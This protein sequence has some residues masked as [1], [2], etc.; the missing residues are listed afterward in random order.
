MGMSLPL[1]GVI[2]A[3]AHSLDPIDG[4]TPD[5]LVIISRHGVRRQFPSSAFDFDKFAPGKHFAASDEEWGA[6]REGFG[7]LTDH[8]FEAVR[9]MGEA[10][11][12]R[13]AMVGTGEPKEWGPGVPL[14]NDI[15]GD[16]AVIYA[17]EGV[18]RD[19]KTAEAFFLGAGCHGRMPPM[20]H[21]G[22]EY[23]IDQGSTP[24]GGEG[25]CSLLDGAATAGRVGGGSG[26]LYAQLPPYAG[27][28]QK[29][30]DLLGC[31]SADLCCGS[32]AA[33]TSS[34]GSSECGLAGLPSAWDAER[35]YVTFQGP[36]Y[37]A[38]YFSE[39]ILLT[40]LNG[41]DFAWGR[42]A[43]AEVMELSAFV[44]LYRTFEFDLP[45]AQSFGSALLAHVAASLDQWAAAA[46][47]QAPLGLVEEVT[48]AL[49]ISVVAHAVGTRLVYYAS[50]DT[51]L[52]YVAELLGLK[53]LSA[54]GW[55]PNH[56]PPG[57]QIV[58]EVFAPDNVANDL[59][60]W[61]TAF[62]FDV[63]TPSQIRSLA[64]LTLQ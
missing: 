41:M 22:T 26:E 42:L 12:L 10:A 37:A 62:F 5:R 49:G 45:A 17:E 61:A 56:T 44:A 34:R 14:G 8:G 30:S 29:L 60:V 52:M 50:H 27:L 13:Y 43:E 1:I 58:V 38:K 11:A 2:F 59:G 6:G 18:A 3:F 25:Q 4:S 20:V 63:Q 16:K 54:G 23:I 51:N 32:I 55:Q 19:I 53:W 35:W 31:C 24:R 33:N 15:C 36:L 40:M 39:W 64:N 57:G 21:E 46:S 9:R 28:L 48:E 7:E 47:A